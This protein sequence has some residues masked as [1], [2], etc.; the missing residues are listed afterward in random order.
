MDKIDLLQKGR[1][2]LQ[3]RLTTDVFLAIDAGKHLPD[4]IVAYA[5]TC[6]WDGEVK[7]P[8]PDSFI[9]KVMRAKGLDGHI[10]IH[11]EYGKYHTVNFKNSFEQ[12]ITCYRRAL[13]YESP[14]SIKLYPGDTERFFNRVAQPI[15][16]K[17][18]SASSGNR[19]RSD[20]YYLEQDVLYCLR[21]DLP[22]ESEWLQS[23]NIYRTERGRGSL[24][25]YIPSQKENNKLTELAT[26]SDGTTLCGDGEQPVVASATTSVPPPS[27]PVSLSSSSKKRQLPSSAITVSMW[28]HIPTSPVRV[29]DNEDGKQNQKRQKITPPSMITT[30]MT[31]L[32]P[33][34]M[35]RLISTSY[36]PG[37]A[38][39]TT[40][41]PH[42]QILYC[43]S[44]WLGSTS[45]G[46]TSSM[47][48]TALSYYSSIPKTAIRPFDLIGARAPIPNTSVIQ[49]SS[50]NYQ[51]PIPK[52]PTIVSRNIGTILAAT[53]RQ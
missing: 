35:P 33:P 28:T 7:G 53:K 6:L 27:H 4:Q 50:L 5:P 37:S 52:L 2:E 47:T 10:G 36:Y 38:L 34:P 22:I 43:P 9:D 12:M 23:V 11:D 29:H 16:P 14:L 17:D 25:P 32:P 20:M 46:L 51:N 48:N 1:T 13:P 30:T 40:Q 3:V 45:S 26:Q 15:E 44:A 24:P 49:N 8:L 19:E 31:S 18:A 42:T 39:N 41:L 21:H